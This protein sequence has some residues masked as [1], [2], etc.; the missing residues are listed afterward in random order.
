MKYVIIGGVAAG[1]SAAMEIYRKDEQAQI[2]VLEKDEYYSYGQCGLPYVISGVVESFDDLIAR[3][4]QTFREKYKMDARIGTI[5]ESINFNEQTLSVKSKETNNQFEVEYDKLLI[6][7]G[8]SSIY[9]EWAGNQL[10]GIHKLGTIPD[11]KELL[12]DLDEDVNNVTIIGGGYIGL[13]AAENIA[14]LGKKVTLIQRGNQ[15]ANIFDADMAEIIHNKAEEKGINLILNEEV[16]GFIGDHY[17]EKVQT[18]KNLYK[19]EVV[20]LGIGVQPNTEFLTH[21]DIHLNDNGAII[22]NAYQETNIK[23]VYAAGDCAT[24]YHRVKQIND[25][26][27]L[28]TTANKQGRIAGAN[29]AN[30]SLT[31][32]GIVGTSIIKFFDITLGRTGITEKEAKSLSIPYKVQKTDANSHAGYYPGYEKLTIKILYHEETNEL[33][34]GQIIGAEGV[35]K[36]VDVL[37]TAL[38]NKMSMS[39]LID[40]DLAYAPPYNS[41]W[42]PIQQMARK[43]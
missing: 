17:V 41:A 6:A 4:L 24:D 30:D 34:G 26:I 7:S 9:P 2:T 11:A 15:V 28:G 42:D 10:N 38:Y 8:A 16:T 13:E 25:Y 14:E 20:L 19:T 29:M 12:K 5:V 31:F 21:T 40:L 43:S 23:N 32:K 18:N 39:D 1:M 3:S 35:D 22:V 37:A 27:P 36:R 33:L